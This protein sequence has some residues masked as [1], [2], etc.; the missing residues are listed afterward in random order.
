MDEDRISAM[1]TTAVILLSNLHCDRY[2]LPSDPEIS[3]LL[4]TFLSCVNV[5]EH[6]LAALQ[7]PPAVLEISIIHQAVIIQHHELSTI[8]IQGTL[9]DAGF[10]VSYPRHESLVMEDPN[11]SPLSGR[12]A[13]H[14]QLCPV[15]RETSAASKD[16]ARSGPQ[17]N[18]IAPSFPKIWQEASED[19][20][21]DEKIN[22]SAHI[23]Q[24]RSVVSVPHRLNLAV[25]GMTCVT[26]SASITE[27]V[28]RISGV[29]QVFVDI[30][31]NSATLVVESKGLIPSITEAIEDRGYG[32]EL[33]KAEP[34]LPSAVEATPGSRTI[35]LQVHGMFC[36]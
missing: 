17:S 32:V 2:A 19:A 4:L 15:C 9:E 16:D 20:S 10:D 6:T 11:R 35:S 26:C 3:H 8:S 25:S 28:S 14:L 18:L 29:S 23:D 30:M 31:N 21:S 36:Q 24:K 34:I 22:T 33:L 12:R 27:G 5:I 1:S 7:P 13:K